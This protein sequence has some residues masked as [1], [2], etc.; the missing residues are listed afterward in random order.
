MLDDA[1][2]KRLLDSFPNTKLLGVVYQYGTGQSGS[3]VFAAHYQP[4]NQ[5]GLK[6]GTFIV[7]IGPEDWAEKEQEFSDTLLDKNPNSLLMKCHM[8]TPALAGQSAVAYEMAF[9]KFLKP[10]TLMDILDEGTDS[11]K[12]A[13]Q[14]IQKLAYALVDWYL[15]KKQPLVRDAHSLLCH[16]LTEKRTGDLLKRI[17]KALPSWEPEASHIMVS[18]HSRFLPNP[19][20]YKQICERISLNLISPA[21]RIH[22]DLHTGNV[23]CF[24]ESEDTPKLIDVDQSVPDG[25]PFFDLAYLEF[26]IIRHLLPVDQEKHRREWLALLN[27]SMTDIQNIPSIA[28]WGASRTWSFLQA[29]RQEVAR[30]LASGSDIYEAVWWLSTVAVGLN[31]ARKGDETRSPFE[32]VA[33]LLYAAYGLSQ[34]LKVLNM[35]EL[36]VEGSPCIV[37]WVEGNFL[38]PNSHEASPLSPLPSNLPEPLATEAIPPAPLPSV[39][40]RAEETLPPIYQSPLPK[41][42]PT[43]AHTPAQEMSDSHS[44]TSLVEVA[45]QEVQE[46]KESQSRHSTYFSATVANELQSMLQETIYHFQAGGYIFKDICDTTSQTLQQFGLFFQEALQKIPDEEY[47]MRFLLDNLAAQQKNLSVDIRNFCEGCPPA[48]ARKL[49]QKR[50]DKERTAISTNLENF[51]I[52]FLELLEKV[53]QE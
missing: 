46:A 29:I 24:L 23:V 1:L 50:Y 19:L 36:P 28:P 4:K 51:Q 20:A 33:G 2:Q 21:T 10:K 12:E 9:G 48:P 42:S 32:R 37:S 47:L 7:K 45:T 8:H 43:L 11:E 3:P 14:Q 53:R 6:E 26:D 22:G 39:V 49:S 44:F 27:A 15:Q 31:F 40:V 16:M 34:F 17:K 38:L 18:G 13:Q 30:L 41:A 52:K 35:Q 5:Y 25:I